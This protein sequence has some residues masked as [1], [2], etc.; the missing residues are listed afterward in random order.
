ME[1]RGRPLHLGRVTIAGHRLQAVR[2]FPVSG[3]TIRMFIENHYSAD[4]LR[5]GAPVTSAKRLASPGWHVKKN[6]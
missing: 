6:T 2:A 5:T 3:A 4:S 1:R